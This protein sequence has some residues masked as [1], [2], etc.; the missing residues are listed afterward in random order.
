MGCGVESTRKSAAKAAGNMQS[1][2]HDESLNLQVSNPAT[3]PLQVMSMNDKDCKECIYCELVNEG[4]SAVCKYPVPGWIKQ[5]CLGGG[6]LSG[7][8]AKE[9]DLFKTIEMVNAEKAAAR[10]PVLL[11]ETTG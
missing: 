8:E 3:P 7:I 9:C 11:N 6:F 2:D 10:E 1:K 4:R 5:G